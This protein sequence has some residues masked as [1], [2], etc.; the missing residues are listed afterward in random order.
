M[1]SQSKGILQ[2]NCNFIAIVIHLAV[3]SQWLCPEILHL[4]R[5]GIDHPP[6]TSTKSMGLLLHACNGRK[7]HPKCLQPGL[8]RP[9]NIDFFVLT[10]DILF[11]T[12]ILQSHPFSPQLLRVILTGK[13][14]PLI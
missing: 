8:R 13:C 3:K 4:S 1:L 10:A 14:F 2:I 11:S 6:Y 12:V 7:I 9:E 5:R